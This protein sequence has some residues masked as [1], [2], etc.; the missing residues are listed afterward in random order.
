[1]TSIHKV[2]DRLSVHLKGVYKYDVRVLD[3]R[4]FCIGALSDRICFLDTGYNR[5][6]T[7]KIIRTMYKGQEI[8]ANTLINWYLLTRW[9]SEQ[10][11]LF[12]EE[13]FD[14]LGDIQERSQ[15]DS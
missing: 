14:K 2:G 10:L 9:Q 4:T 3:K 15:D 6:E 7:I 5:E 11:S 1:M 8:D 12:R 13:L